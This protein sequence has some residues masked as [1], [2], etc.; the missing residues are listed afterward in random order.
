ML[1][2]AMTASMQCTKCTGACK[3]PGK[4]AKSLHKVQDHTTLCLLASFKRHDSYTRTHLQQR[5]RAVDDLI[6]QPLQRRQ[7]LHLATCEWDV[8]LRGE[9]QGFQHLGNWN[10]CNNSSL[11]Q[12]KN[13]EA[14]KVLDHF[15]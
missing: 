2:A 10:T 7:A 13:S 4:I 9:Q 5:H 1:G 12:V 3:A 6:I 14:S 8:G 11:N 15:P